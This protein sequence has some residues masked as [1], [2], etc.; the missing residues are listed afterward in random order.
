MTLL[1]AGL[2]E[3]FPGAS[4]QVVNLG[5][6]FPMLVERLDHISMVRDPDAPR[7]SALVGG[8]VFDTASLGP[9]S[10]EMA[11]A[12]LGAERILFGTDYPIF[13]TDVATTGLGTARITEA[14]REAIA[15]RNAARL[16][17]VDPGTFPISYQ[18]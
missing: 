7:P 12:V 3:R 6:A 11:V 13:A 2:S 1:H 8:L 17:R 15:W 18:I 16:L 5:G 4:V 10:I 14:A 9:R